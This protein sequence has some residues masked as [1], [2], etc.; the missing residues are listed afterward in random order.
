M[1]GCS[2]Y[3]ICT[4]SDLRSRLLLDFIFC[5]SQVVHQSYLSWINWGNQFEDENH[6]GH[7]DQLR[8]T[9]IVGAMNYPY[10]PTLAPSEILF[11]HN[12]DSQ[13]SQGCPTLG[14]VV[15]FTALVWQ[16]FRQV[17][18]LEAGRDQA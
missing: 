2:R 11:L 14:N 6:M 3:V 10:S 8:V 16:L 1:H 15:N 5:L 12:E 18:L 9:R 17:C 7:H 4:L 13:K